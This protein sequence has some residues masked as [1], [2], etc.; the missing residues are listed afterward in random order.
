VA[1]YSSAQFRVQHPNHIF[2]VIISGTASTTYQVSGDA[3]DVPNL[4]S[5]KV[6]DI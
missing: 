6:F 5:K 2:V 1:F 3:Y 4:S